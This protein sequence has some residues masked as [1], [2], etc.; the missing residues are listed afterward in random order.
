M[1]HADPHPAA[2]EA[3]DGQQC[4]EALAES[5]IL[6]IVKLFKNSRRHRWYTYPWKDTIQV[7]IHH[8]P[9]VDR[10]EEFGH[11]LDPVAAMKAMK[12]AIVKMEHGT[13]LRGDPHLLFREP[14][15]VHDKKTG[16]KRYSKGSRRRMG[17]GRENMAGRGTFV[18][19]GPTL[20]KAA[21]PRT[22][23]TSQFALKYNS[24]SLSQSSGQEKISSATLTARQL[25][26]HNWQ[27]SQYFPCDVAVIVHQTNPTRLRAICEFASKDAD[28]IL[29]KFHD[30][31]HENVIKALQCFRVQDVV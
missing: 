14:S 26:D 20:S 11:N 12:L 23:K 7:E 21:N 8:P 2:P 3:R 10:G 27:G 17:N 30:I 5:M 4:I 13:S 1:D 22:A 29:E 6:V 18:K 16:S 9:P 15:S 24:F 19:S 28:G 25:K 31:D